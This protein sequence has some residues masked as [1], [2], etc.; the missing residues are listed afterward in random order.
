MHHRLTSI[1]F[2]FAS[3]LLLSACGEADEEISEAASE[4]CPSEMTASCLVDQRVCV[5]SSSAEPRCE[6]CPEGSYATENACEP[7]GAE[8]LSHDF[9]EFS[10]KAGEE[11]LGLCQSWTL[12]NATELWINGVE[13]VQDVVSHHSNWTFV[14]DTQF[15]GPDGVW[16][17]KE[18]SYSQLTAA[19]SGGV[20][21]AQSTQATKEVQKFPDGAA[22]R[23]PPY[24]RVIGDVH[25]LNTTAEEITGHVRL[26]LYGLPLDDVKVKLAPF[27]LTFETLDIQP[28]STTRVTGECGLEENFQSLTGGPL[29]MTL[30]YALPHTHALGTRMF[31]EVMGGPN[32]GQ[33]LLDVKGFNGEARGKSYD[34]FV[35]LDGA[36]GFRFGCEFENPRDESVHWG[37]DDQEM[38]EMLGFA[39]TALVFEGSVKELEAPTMDGAVYDVKGKGCDML[40][41]PWSHDKPGGNGP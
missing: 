17:C 2:A 41:V 31:F 11:V 5:T 8:S 18:R 13:L 27:H 30:Y 12:G 37:F 24:A 29:A 34:P 25:L 16:L 32:D 28:L 36:T 21:Y 3:A 1:A 35:V 4:P 9:A 33:S 6:S 10:V 15:A 22:V 14:P 40:A 23:I 19:L 26:N 38:C 39:E 20:L 7:I